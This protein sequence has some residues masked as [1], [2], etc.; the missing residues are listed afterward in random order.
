MFPQALCL[1]LPNAVLAFTLSYVMEEDFNL[2]TEKEENIAD[3]AWKLWAGFT[4]VLFFVLYFRSNVAYSRWWEGG[5]LLQKTRGEWFN[6]YSSLIAFSSTDPAKEAQVEEFHH[7]LAR[8]MSLL[9]SAALQQ[10]SP[11]KNRPFEIIHSEGID[12]KSLEFL[13]RSQDKV[14]VILQWIQRST[15][16]NMSSG[17]LPIP[18]PVMSR[19]FQEISR[20]IVNLQN[21]RKIADFPFPFPYAQTSVVMLMLHWCL[22]PVVST[23]LLE[24]YTAAGIC[25][26]VVFFLWCINYI[27]LCLEQPFGSDDNDLPMEQMQADWNKSI[28]TLLAKRAQQP[29]IFTFQPAKHRRLELAIFNGTMAIPITRFPDFPTDIFEEPD[30]DV[31]KNG[32]MMRRLSMQVMGHLRM[33]KKS[34][35]SKSPG[36]RRSTTSS[37][38]PGEQLQGGVTQSATTSWSLQPTL[39]SADVVA[40]GGPERAHS[41]RSVASVESGPART[42]DSNGIEGDPSLASGIWTA[43]SG[44]ASASEIAAQRLKAV[45]VPLSHASAEPLQPRAQPPAASGIL[46]LGGPQPSPIGPA[47]GAE[48]RRAAKS[49]QQSAAISGAEGSDSSPSSG[50]DQSQLSSADREAVSEDRKKSRRKP[51]TWPEHAVPSALSVNASPDRLAD[52]RNQ[53]NSSAA[54]VN[55]EMEMDVMACEIALEDED[56]DDI[57]GLVAGS[58]R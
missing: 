24:K 49:R 48:V 25:F 27:A 21:A 37:T 39:Q 29:P 17:V 20:G 5:T 3:N 53:G 18:P 55:R 10:V 41:S 44:S 56:A 45:A 22:C 36:G 42:G 14:E 57:G 30:G 32:S 28:G 31:A 16:I 52:F 15:I 19:A 47:A 33:G 8:F 46:S 4:S 34:S 43:A 12:V 11:D 7:M 23:M 38:P 35:G 26:A 13:N 50:P 1:A 54:S 9:F 40:T 6:A 2:P 58:L 51:N